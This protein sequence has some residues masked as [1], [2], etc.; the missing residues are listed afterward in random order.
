MAAV[1]LGPT[2]A[3]FLGRV[4]PGL[5]TGVAERVF[6]QWVSL[7]LLEE[8][9]LAQPSTHRWSV[10]KLTPPLVVSDA[11]VDRAVAAVAKI[12]GDYREMLPLLRDVGA[13]LG[14][15]FEGGWSF[16]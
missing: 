6:G 7:R 2:D 3:G 13:R 10:L 4:F 8:G 15:Q 12:L 16:R 11:E 9:I 5:V 1:E 14:E